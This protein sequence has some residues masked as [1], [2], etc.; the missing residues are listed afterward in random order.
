M[1]ETRKRERTASLVAELHRLLERQLEQIAELEKILSDEPTTTSQTPT[2][3][4][5]WGHKWAAAHEGE[6]YV[7]A[8][9]RDGAAFKRLLKALPLEEIIGRMEAF[10]ADTDPWLVQRRHPL[11]VFLKNIN[12]IGPTHQA[13]APVI[14]CS[15]VPRCTSEAEHTKKRL[16][17]V[18]GAAH[19]PAF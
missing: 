10:L 12:S 17:E 13:P 8:Q 5:A 4:A 19:D 11:G 3:F 7:F 1:T 18:R 9:G 16:A 2:L 15:H 6:K 14:G